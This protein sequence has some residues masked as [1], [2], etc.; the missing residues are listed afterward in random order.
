MSGGRVS[1]EAATVPQAS[2]W[3]GVKGDN[4]DSAHLPTDL[5]LPQA[6]VCLLQTDLSVK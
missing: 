6:L 5:E 1:Q 2:R 3:V 4:K